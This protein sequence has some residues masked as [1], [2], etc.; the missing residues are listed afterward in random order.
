LINRFLQ[1]QLLFCG[2]FVEGN[3]QGVL[4][5]RHLDLIE[6]PTRRAKKCVDVK[7]A[8]HAKHTASRISWL[9]T[10]PNTEACQSIF[11]K[12][13]KDEKS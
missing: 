4:D 5:V 9:N 7:L 3:I 12:L 2:Q 10:W 11:L 8:P 13:T 1:L 6:G